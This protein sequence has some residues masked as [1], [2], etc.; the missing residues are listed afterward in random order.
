MNK[1]ILATLITTIAAAPYAVSANEAAKTAEPAAVSA[2]ATTEMKDGSK[3]E[4]IGDKAEL[5]GKD[6]KKTPAPDGEYTL[7]DGSKITTKG[8][9]VVKK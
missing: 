9:V 7:K 6:G 4:V 8:G 1:I 5:I 3:L 2:S